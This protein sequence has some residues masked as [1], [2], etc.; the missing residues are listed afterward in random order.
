MF[1]LQLDSIGIN[2]VDVLKISPYNAM[3]YGAFVLLLIYI[4]L[5]LKGE[6]KLANEE[7]KR[8]TEQNHKAFGIVSDKLNSI[9]YHNESRDG[10]IIIA[11]E[12]IKRRL[13]TLFNNKT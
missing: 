10:S 13:E 4:A 2:P 12:D 7:N 8:L 1:S 6:L 11:L 5:Y 3:A 9:K